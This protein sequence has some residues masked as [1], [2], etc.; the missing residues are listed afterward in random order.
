MALAKILITDVH[1]LP[2]VWSVGKSVRSGSKSSESFAHKEL[3]FILWVRAPP[4]LPL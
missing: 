4:F 3:D 1:K 2:E